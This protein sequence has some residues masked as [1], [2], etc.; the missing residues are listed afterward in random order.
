VAVFVQLIDSDKLSGVVSSFGDGP[1]QF[2]VVCDVPILE[3]GLLHLLADGFQTGRIVSASKE[4]SL[5]Q[6]SNQRMHSFLSQ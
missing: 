1:F 2:N 5:I 6:I 4:E 3:E